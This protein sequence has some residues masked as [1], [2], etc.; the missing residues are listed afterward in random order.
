MGVQYFS[1]S[2]SASSVMLQIFIGNSSVTTG[3][4]LIGLAYNTGSLICYGRLSTDATAT[5]ITLVDMTLGVY[6]SGGFKEIDS[7]HMPGWYIFCPPNA[8]ITGANTTSAFALTGAANMRQC[9]IIV[10]LTVPDVNLTKIDNNATSS[11]SAT[12]NLKQLNVVNTG[13]DAVIFSSTGTNGR[14]LYC[15]GNGTGAGFR[16]LGGTTGN[17]GEY[18]GG[19]TSGSGVLF[20][21]STSGYGIY[22]RS[23]GANNPAIY[24][25]AGSATGVSPGF[26]ALGGGT[27]AG[28]RAEAFGSANG[29]DALSGGAT[30]NGINAVGSGTGSGMVLTGVGAASLLATQGI[31]GPLDA[32]ERIAIA[33]AV[34]K[35]D[36]SA[37]TGEASRSLLNCCRIIRNKWSI[38]G[39]VV[40]VTKE[41]DT[42]T[43]WTATV[44]TDVTALPIVSFDGS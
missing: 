42:T 9:P 25:D 27:G 29:I 24:A 31:S 5:A 38:S 11:N 10:S 34:F 33:D 6:T 13:G 30:G 44:G 32:S 1:Y 23:L 16:A 37:I 15:A 21:T 3:A 26:K 19:N 4:G 36:M 8:F 14:G 2:N 17:G 40:T 39:G 20:T 18:V 12:L 28:I 22:C 7:T 43:A 41:D 35:R